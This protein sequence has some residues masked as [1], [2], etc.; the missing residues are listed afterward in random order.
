ME[1]DTPSVLVRLAAREDA[2]SVASVLRES[3]E[4]FRPLYTLEGFDATTPAAEQVSS[5]I[6]EGPVWVA[7]DD[8]NNVVGTVSVVAKG[9]SLYVRGMAIR[10]AARGRRIGELLLRQVEAFARERGFSRMFLS[11]TPFLERAI[12]LY[13]R[14]GFERTAEGP[15]NLFGTPLFTMEK[16]LGPPDERALLD[17][18]ARALFTHDERSRLLSVNEPWGGRDPAP[19]IYL[20]RTRA[21][22]LRRFRADLPEEL[23]V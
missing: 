19:R 2:P 22:N 11:T 13:E 12:R 6:E 9:E 20:G 15:D 21:G 1:P 14:N 4:E 17:V 3:F 8:D 10:P 18:H 16:I 5:R 23:V 7:S